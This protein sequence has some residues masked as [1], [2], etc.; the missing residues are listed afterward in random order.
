MFPLSDNTGVR[1]TTK[2]RFAD[3]EK[4]LAEQTDLIHAQDSRLAGHDELVANHTTKLED[5]DSRVKSVESKPSGRKKIRVI[6][7]SL[8]KITDRLNNRN[9]YIRCEIKKQLNEALSPLDEEQKRLSARLDAVHDDSTLH[10]VRTEEAFEKAINKQEEKL[11]TLESNLKLK[12][13]TQRRQF[14]DLSKRVA[15]LEEKGNGDNEPTLSKDDKS[16][17]NY[18]SPAEPS[19][20]H[21]IARMTQLE[22]IVKEKTEEIAK[23]QEALDTLKIEMFYLKSTSDASHEFQ[24][25]QNDNQVHWLPLPSQ[26]QDQTPSPQIRAC[27]LAPRPASV[28]PP[29]V[30]QTSL[31]ASRPAPILAGYQYSQHQSRQHQGDYR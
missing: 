18:V 3:C 27:G 19:M 30:A 24:Q 12:R 25:W 16:D 31:L 11:T 9:S 1:R 29:A 5:L 10:K 7:E 2:T 26:H 28:R 22:N 13:R 20:A 8:V 4:Q 21:V 15:G 17:D 14:I 23:Q 6:Q